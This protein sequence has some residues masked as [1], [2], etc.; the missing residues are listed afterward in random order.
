[1]T[2]AV[3][4]LKGLGVHLKGD[5]ILEYVVDEDLC[6]GCGKCVE[7]CA[8]FGNGSLY[9]QVKHDLCANCNECEIAR[10]CPANAFQRVPAEDAYLLKTR[11][12]GALEQK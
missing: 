9:L 5:V 8:R 12:K 1:M 6:I 7:G 4:I 2:M 3:S 10:G 11:Q